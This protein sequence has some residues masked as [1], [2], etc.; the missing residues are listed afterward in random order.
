VD[1]DECADIAASYGVEAM[2]TFVFIRDGQEIQSAR[3]Q[4]AN[5]KAL[6]RGIDLHSAAPAAAVSQ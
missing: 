2:P 6:S 1:V 5:V 3:V 4:G